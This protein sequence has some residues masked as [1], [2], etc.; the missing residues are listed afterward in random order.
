MLA[1]EARE[2]LVVVLGGVDALWSIHRTLS[3]STRTAVGELRQQ[4]HNRGIRHLPPDR[5]N[6][7]RQHTAQH[8]ADLSRGGL[9]QVHATSGR[10]AHVKLTDRGDDLA[11]TAINY[12]TTAA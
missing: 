3:L 4:Y 1:G 9:L 12:P 8:L 7:G 6:R 10:A 11:R 5:T 2:T